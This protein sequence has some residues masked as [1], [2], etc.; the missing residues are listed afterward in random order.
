MSNLLEKSPIEKMI[1]AF[2]EYFIFIEILEW[3]INGYGIS[4][5]A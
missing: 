4:E 2:Y 3:G 1:L 5:N